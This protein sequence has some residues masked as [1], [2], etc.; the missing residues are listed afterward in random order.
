MEK[1]GVDTNSDATKTASNKSTCPICG[2]ALK[3]G[4]NVPTCPTHGT[5]P[6]ERQRDPEPDVREE[7]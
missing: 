4:T 7:D 5:A 2:A 1:L 3:E 6:F